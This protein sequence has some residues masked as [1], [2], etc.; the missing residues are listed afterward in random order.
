[1][2]IGRRL[3]IKFCFADDIVVKAEEEE[4]ADL[5]LDRLDTTTTP[6]KMEIGPDKTKVRINNTNCFQM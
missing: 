6:Y 4:E 2:T 5:L 1:M 3:I